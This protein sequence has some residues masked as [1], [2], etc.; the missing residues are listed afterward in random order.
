MTGIRM[1]DQAGSSDKRRHALRNVYLETGGLA[2]LIAAA[3]TFLNERPRGEPP[4][5][6]PAIGILVVIIGLVGISVVTFRY[7][8]RT[9][10]H[11]LLANLWGLTY[12]YMFLLFA[13]PAWWM[14]NH[15]GVVGPIDFWM[16]Y[17]GSAVVA[18]VAWA[19]YRFR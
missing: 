5:Y 18:A 13:G 8:K 3:A 1:A 11:D 12:G 7:L 4:A 16:I 10:E 9:D 6:S 17:F 2:V 14:L 15:S 19:W